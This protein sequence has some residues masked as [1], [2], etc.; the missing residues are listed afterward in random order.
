MPPRYPLFYFE[1]TKETPNYI[2]HLIQV[3]VH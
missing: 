2:V 1:S 3:K